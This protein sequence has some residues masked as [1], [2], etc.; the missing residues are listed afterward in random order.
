MSHVSQAARILEVLDD[1]RWHTVAEIHRRA[2]YS[3]LNSRVSELRNKHGHAIECRHVKG[4][5]GTEGY[6]YRLIK[7]TTPV[8]DLLDEDDYAVIAMDEESQLELEW[9]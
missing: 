9:K 7:P 3:R 2:G 4:K 1:E 8:E 5:T 6:E